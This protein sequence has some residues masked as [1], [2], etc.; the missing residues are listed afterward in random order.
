MHHSVRSSGSVPVK[1]GAAESK[2][3]ED[4]AAEVIE[5]DPDAV[6]VELDAV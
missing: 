2:D 5:A 3:D 1:V 4:D 6:E